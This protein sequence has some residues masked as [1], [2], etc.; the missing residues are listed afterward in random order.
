[1]VFGL[2]LLSISDIEAMSLPTFLDWA[3]RAAEWNS[4]KK[5]T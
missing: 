3:R 5:A 4:R 1:M 2:K